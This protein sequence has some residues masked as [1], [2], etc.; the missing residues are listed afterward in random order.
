MLVVT[1]AS[2]QL[3]RAVARE[4]AALRGGGTGLV[5]ATRDPAALADGPAGA[6]PRRADFG[7]PGSL[8]IAFSGADRVLVIST[9]DIDGRAAGQIAAID[10]AKAA[11]ARHILYTSMLS[12]V[13]E[14]PAIIAPSHRATEEHLR[15]SGV[16]FTILRAGFYAD[17][18]VYEAAEALA[19]GRLVHN[20]DAGR[21]AYLTRAD[22]ARAAAAV[23][24]GGGHEGETLDL[25]GTEAYDAAGLAAEYA[26]V[27]GREV[28]AVEVGDAELLELLGGSAEGHNQYGARLTVSIG[29]AIRGGFLDVVTDTVAALT[30]SAPEPLSSVLARSA[31]TLRR[32]D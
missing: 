3:G 23:L 11:G 25:T 30:G 14:N 21:C 24:V 8:A 17:F 4:A 26:A 32:A 1:G 9:D 7:D 27:G 28:E 16:A 6:E 2:G 5:L 31:E 18:Q 13:P 22:I 10:A 15:S 29:Q 19:S 20:R 12:P